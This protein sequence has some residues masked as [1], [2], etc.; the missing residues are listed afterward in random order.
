MIVDTYSSATA[1]YRSMVG[2]PVVGPALAAVA[3][4]A[5]VA[6]G[7]K[8]LSAIYAAKVSG[9]ALGGVIDRPTY[10]LMGEAGPEIVAPKDTFIQHSAELVRAAINSA[11]YAGGSSQSKMMSNLQNE[12]SNLKN[13]FERYADK[14]TN[15]LIGDNECIKIKNRANTSLGFS[16]I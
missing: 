8:N 3:A 9:Y 6:M 11:G 1:A 4:A 13:S 12:V 2:I 10:A 14:A 7:I 5:A 16:K 15:I